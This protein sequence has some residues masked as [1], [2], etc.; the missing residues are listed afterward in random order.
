VITPKKLPMNPKELDKQSPIKIDQWLDIDSEDCKDRDPD[1]SLTKKW[2]KI[3]VEDNFLYVDSL[4]RI[5]GMGEKG[6]FY[7]YHFNVGK[8]LYGYRMSVMAAN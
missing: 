6:Y 2:F 7:P 3:G 1:H 5:W 4:G 8:K